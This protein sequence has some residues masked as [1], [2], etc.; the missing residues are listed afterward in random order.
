ML[1]DS[2]GIQTTATVG[3]GRKMQVV[4]SVQEG[5]AKIKLDGIA[6]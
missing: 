4:G 2:G 3:G 1:D 5:A 6:S